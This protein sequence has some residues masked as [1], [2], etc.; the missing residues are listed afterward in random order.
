MKYPYLPLAAALL[1]THPPVATAAEPDMVITATRLPEVAAPLPNT[2]VITRDEIATRQSLTLA[3]LLQQE[4]GITVASN[5]G[6]FTTAGLFLRGSAGKQVLVLV[7]GVRVNDAS[8]GA[9]DLSLL[10]ADDIERIEIVR[11]PYSSQYGSDA[12]GGVVQVFTRQAAKAEASARAGRFGTR[13]FGVGVRAGDRDNGLSLRAGYADSDGFNSTRPGNLAYA[14]DRDGGLARTVQLNGNAKLSPDVRASFS[15]HWRDSVTE[16]DQGLSNQDHATASARIEQAM[17]GRWTQTL[18]LGWLHNRLDTDGRADPFAPYLSRFQTD[19]DTLGWLHEV[20]WQEGWQTVAG[21]DH[22]DERAESSDLLAGR[23][24]IDTRLQNSGV[25]VTQHGRA[26]RISGAASVRRDE[27]DTFGGQT[28]GSLSLAAEVTPATKLFAAYGSA[29]RAPSAND[30]Y[31]PG[32]PS[33]CWPPAPGVSC[34]PG[35]PAL[36]PE[37]ARSGEVGAEWRGDGQRLRISAY[38]NRV[39][40]LVNTS[41]AF[42]YPL[43]NEARARLQ[44]IE[45]DASGRVAALTWRLNAGSHSAEDGQGNDLVRRPQGTFNGLLQVAA[46]DT[47]DLGTEV[48]SRSSIRDSGQRVGG[49]TVFNV[50]AGWQALPS[51]QLGA[52]LENAGNKDYQELQGYRAAPRSGYLTATWTWR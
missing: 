1:G 4:A 13:E 50:F 49:Y 22:E 42:P 39:R 32:D 29:F 31:Y 12:I 8:Q 25:F 27:H 45:L 52:R 2:T 36:K 16:F 26:G 10:R 33:F 41:F 6:A 20:T 28:T 17:S 9:F 34:Y 11:G 24:L 44:G 37:K 5:G 14:P 47:V 30:L 18:Q 40:N 43:I 7:D 46:T 35:N 21:L 48:R 15:T 19:R 23:R 51:L 3:D 38:R